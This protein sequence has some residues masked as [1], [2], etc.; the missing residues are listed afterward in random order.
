VLAAVARRP[1]RFDDRCDYTGSPELL[2]NLARAVVCGAAGEI[3]G[4]AARSGDVPSG[5]V[6]A[7][8]ASRCGAGVRGA[9]RPL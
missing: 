4:N 5:G 9:A 2:G 3:A 1:V 6:L 7:R 8:G